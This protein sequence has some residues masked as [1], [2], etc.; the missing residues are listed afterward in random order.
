MNCN[1]TKTHLEAYLT[2]ALRIA[3]ANQVR[4]HLDDC[5][6]CWNTWN[7]YRWE[8]AS[9]TPLYHDLASY[10]GPRFRPGFDSSRALARE[11][12]QTAPR[13]PDQIAD[14]FRSSLS[15]L[16]NLVIWEAS[17]NRPGYCVTAAPLLAQLGAQTVIDYGS[18]IGSDTLALR[19][20]SLN[21]IPCDYSSPSTRFY[22]WR[23]RRLQQDPRFYEPGHL[24]QPLSADTMWIIDTLDHLPDLEASIGHLLATTRIRI[25]ICENPAAGR[26][27]GHQGFHH[28]RHATDIAMF[29]TGH[30]FQQAALGDVASSI[31]CWA[32]PRRDQH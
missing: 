28:R 20:L 29:Y 3:A 22:Q 19:S 25:I 17:G 1:V 11:W 10:L 14:F 18:G 30:G 26:G 27:H 24:P 16:Y 15:Y 6:C 9:R 2:H 7:E 31:Q 8:R 5:P 21:V 12:A 4:Q 32:R 23:A 13:T